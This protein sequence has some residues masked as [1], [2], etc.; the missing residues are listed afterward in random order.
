MWRSAKVQ[1][2]T[3]L[4]KANSMLRVAAAHHVQPVPRVRKQRALLPKSNLSLAPQVKAKKTSYAQVPTPTTA[5]ASKVAAGSNSSCSRR[6]MRWT[7]KTNGARTHPAQ[8]CCSTKLSRV[9]V[10]GVCGSSQKKS[11]LWQQNPW[12]PSAF[13]VTRLYSQTNHALR[14]LHLRCFR[15]WPVA[16]DETIPNEEVE[17]IPSCRCTIFRL[18]DAL[19]KP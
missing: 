18:S 4:E 7:S 19:C 6:L 3:K 12:C 17:I 14:S 11:C 9:Q 1:K 16:F 13:Q 2:Y 5:M 8:F 15:G 10:P